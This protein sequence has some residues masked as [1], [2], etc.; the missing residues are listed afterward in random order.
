MMSLFPS[1]TGA[2]YSYLNT[3]GVEQRFFNQVFSPFGSLFITLRWWKNI[4]LAIISF[5]SLNYL[6]YTQDTIDELED[7]ST[8]SKGFDKF[9]EVTLKETFPVALIREFICDSFFGIAGFTILWIIIR[10]MNGA[11]ANPVILFLRVLGLQDPE[12]RSSRTYSG[13]SSVVP[14]SEDS[15]LQGYQNM[16]K[17]IM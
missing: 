2:I 1:T 3:F 12:G 9:K 14:D 15:I 17:S 5:I 8:I 16:L 4:T 13:T 11:S 7:F 10:N 6:F